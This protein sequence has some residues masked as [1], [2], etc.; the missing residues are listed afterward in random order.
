MNPS[1]IV[2]LGKI[3]GLLSTCDTRDWIDFGIACFLIILIGV[4]V[5]LMN[6]K[7]ALRIVFGVLFVCLIPLVLF[8]LYVAAALLALIIVGFLV[9]VLLTNYADLREAL[10]NS[11]KLLPHKKGKNPTRVE[12]DIDKLYRDVQTAVMYMSDHKMGAI[13]TFQ[14][15]DPVEIPPDGVILDA[16]FVPELVETIFFSGTRLH[17]MGMVVVGNTIHAAAV[18][19]P[20]STRIFQGKYGS[21]HRAAVGI[22]EACPDSVTVVVS[23][24]T[25][26]ISIAHNGNLTH[27]ANRDFS[28]TFRVFMDMG[29]PEASQKSEDSDQDIDL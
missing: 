10:E 9:A 22:S 21:R 18:R 2:M 16:P 23:E 14:K 5:I 24:E 26:R 12:Y 13:I 11:R 25:G 4:G 6:K 7:A 19:F 17:D 15:E 1:G 8:Q 27:V 3:D 29:H 28:S 20:V